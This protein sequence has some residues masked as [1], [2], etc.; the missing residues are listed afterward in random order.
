MCRLPNSVSYCDGFQQRGF[1]LATEMSDGFLPSK[2]RILE[3]YGCAKNSDG[4]LTEVPS[5]E[6]LQYVYTAHAGSDKARRIGTR[7]ELRPPSYE[8][9]R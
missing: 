6:D 3:P 5:S 1:R 8:L 7:S 2:C 4:E 9:T